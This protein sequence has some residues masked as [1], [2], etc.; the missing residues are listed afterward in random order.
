MEEQVLKTV[1]RFG[2]KLSLGVP[3]KSPKKQRLNGKHN[4]RDSGVSGQ[5]KGF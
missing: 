4:Q 2:I 3:L 1:I 5:S